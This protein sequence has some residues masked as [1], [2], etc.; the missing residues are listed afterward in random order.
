LIIKIQDSGKGI[1]KERNKFLFKPFRELRSKQYLQKVVDYSY[2][3][4]LSCSYELANAIGG[5]LKLMK[6]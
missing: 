2:G 3:L 1:E 4:G 6:L 5:E